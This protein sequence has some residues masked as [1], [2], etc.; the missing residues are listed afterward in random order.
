M[1]QIQRGSQTLLSDNKRRK[2]IQD[3]IDFYATV[4]NETIGVIAAETLLD[5]LLDT[6][7]KDLYNKGVDD[8]FQFVHERIR[9][10]ETDMNAL[11]KK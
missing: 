5:F 2:T 1:T 8:A 3:I 7:G 4:R 11:V 10:A 6:I 9:S